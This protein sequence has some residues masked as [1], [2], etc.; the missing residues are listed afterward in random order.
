M[1]AMSEHKDEAWGIIKELMTSDYNKYKYN[2]DGI[3]V[4][5]EEF[6]M[7]A[8]DVTITEPY[9]TEDGITIHP[10]N[11]VMGGSNITIGPATKDDVDKLK[12]MIQRV[13]KAKTL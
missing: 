13:L 10:Q 7:M 9:T 11:I 5:K 12:D 3:P 6:D 4:S 2:S 8:H 1:F